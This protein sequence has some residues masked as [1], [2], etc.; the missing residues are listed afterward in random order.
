MYETRIV[1]NDAPSAHMIQTRKNLVGG[2]TNLAPNNKLSS[3]VEKALFELLDYQQRALQQQIEEE[4]RSNELKRQLTQN[5][6]VAFRSWLRHGWEQ[7][8]REPGITSEMRTLL[9]KGERRDGMTTGSVLAG[10]GG[11]YPGSLA[12]FF[13]PVEFS[14]QVEAAMKYVTPMLDVCSFIDSATGSPLG[15]PTDSDINT[16]GE[17]VP[18]TGQ[19]TAN[20]DPPL[21]EANFTSYK[22]SSK[23][24][25]LSMELLQDSAFPLEDYLSDKFA[26]RIGRV[27]NPLLTNGTGSGQPKGLLTGLPVGATAVGSSANTGGSENGQNTIGSDDLIALEQSVDPIYRRGAAYMMHDNTLAYVKGLKDKNGRPL[28]VWRPEGGPFGSINGIYPVYPN[29]DMPQMAAGNA[30]VVFGA[31]S[32]YFVRRAGSMWVKRLTE[33]Y[34]DYGQV[35]FI[36]LARR[37]GMLIDAGTAPVKALLQH[38]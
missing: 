22:Y 12:G 36:A 8:D 16:I 14:G 13:A 4:R 25:K 1:N 28:H 30:S 32:K 10:G 35:A 2:M 38:S 26:Y 5:Y 6:Q 34:A 29:P 19:Y 21:S 15:Y 7:T 9:M 17:Q 23:V 37:D 24:V 27:L 18:E 31:L 3:P 20:A 11:A 33:R